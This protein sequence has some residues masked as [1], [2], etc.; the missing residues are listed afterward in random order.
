MNASDIKDHVNVLVLK[1]GA[2]WDTANYFTD[3]SNVMR[4]VASATTVFMDST[5][6]YKMNMD[7]VAMGPK[8]GQLLSQSF[9]KVFH[10]SC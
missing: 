7:I 9:K 3:V 10:L 4:S 1:R 2:R 8:N 5:N 6:F